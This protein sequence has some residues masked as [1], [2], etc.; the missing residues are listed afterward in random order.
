MEDGGGQARD[1]DRELH[2]DGQ[3]ALAH[4]GVAVVEGDG[5]V[6]LHDET[7]LA[8]LGDAV[9][10]AAVLEAAGDPDR[11]PGAAG[12]VVGVLHRV[13]GLPQ[14]DR[15][16]EHLAC[17]DGVAD[18]HRVAAAD[19]PAVEAHLL[20]EQVEA[21]LDGKGRLRDAEAA[22]GPAG[23]VVRVDGE[24]LHVDRAD[25]VR[26]AGVAGRA[27][28]HLAPDRGVSTRVA[29]EARHDGGEPAL[30]V[31]AHGVVETDGV[32]LR[33]QA[34]R[35]LAGEDQLHR[36]ARDA[37]EER[38]L[39]LDRHVLL[40]PE[41]PAARHELHADVLLRHAEEERDLPAVVEDTLALR[42]EPEAAVRQRLRERGLR[43]QE[44]VLDPLCAPRA[45]HDVGTRGQ[46][47]RGVAPADDRARQEVRVLRVDPGGAGGEGGLG[48]EEGRQGLVLDLDQRRRRARR[49]HIVGR[50]RGEDVADAA[51]LL[52]LGHEARP[53]GVQEA[54]PPLAGH[55]CRRDDDAHP[56]KRRGLRRVDAHDPGP[57][58]RGE[59]EGAVQEAL[60]LHVGH[61][62]LLA[63]GLA[64]SAVAGERLPDAAIVDRRRHLAAAP[65][66]CHQL[67]GL[68]DLRVAGAAAEVPVD[69]PGDLLTARVRLPVEQVL[70][71]ERDPGDAEAALD[72][73]GRGERLR[74]DL[75]LAGRDT[76]EGQHL[77]ALGPARL[78]GAGHERAAVD[79]RQAAAALPLGLAAVLD[80]DDPAALPQRVEE[81]LPGCRLDRRRPAVEGEADASHRRRRPRPR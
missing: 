38:R 24:R 60:A 39:G 2:E 32:T 6:P 55:V 37:R 44:E 8:P 59:D 14:A 5:P 17:G 51:H 68:D 65:G 15:L 70:G 54:V 64:E 62:G 23:R 69:R 52:A 18:G 22:H 36:P 50:H 40:A 78:E 12:A 30:G 53:V 41:G 47:G 35:L 81:R 66:L 3:Q 11:L 7:A 58:V 43:L 10:D 34:N 49:A 26:T 63:E 79:E 72:A 48:I 13:E 19:L 1:L 56:G 77:A 75:A 76:L 21:T 9:A 42:V 61:V 16:L 67:H 31:A 28:E 20:C 71:A 29:D 46:G 57:R 45:G 33:V 25:L 73:A 27:L 74:D 80:R 4:L